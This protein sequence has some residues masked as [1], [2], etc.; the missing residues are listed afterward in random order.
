MVLALA[1]LTR[2]PFPHTPSAARAPAAA[3]WAYPLVGVVVGLLALA[4]GWAVQWLGATAPITAMVV[5]A[6]GIVVTGAMHED[7]LADCADGFWGGWTV[8][9]RLEIMKDS[10]I[11]TYGVIAL[12]MSLLTR[13]Y[14]LTM[15]IDKGAL[16]GA[17][18]VSA[19]I[20]RAA[21]VGVMHW[22]PNAR[23]IGLS[24]QTGRPAGAP[25][26][27]ALGIAVVAAVAAPTVSMFWLL[28][29]AALVT[30]AAGRV[31]RRKIGGQTGDVL[32][33]TQQVVEITVLVA[34]DVMISSW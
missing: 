33:A 16:V 18:L 11:G 32:G 27:M 5:L 26:V 13:W 3:A 6:T 21:M 1:L 25:T 24:A 12:V 2:L 22:L 23:K 4:V 19:V 31:A 34:F 29:F 17:V 7:G 10:Q 28:I 20:S 30:V 9:R 8:A 14:V 15:L